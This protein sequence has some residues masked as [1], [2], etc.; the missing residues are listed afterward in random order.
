M[1]RAATLRKQLTDSGLLTTEELSTLPDL[2]T[3]ERVMLGPKDVGQENLRRTWHAIDHNTSS[4]Q[5]VEM[6]GVGAQAVHRALNQSSCGRDDD[7]ARDA[8]L[9]RLTAIELG[10]YA[11]QI[12]SKRGT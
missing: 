7:T 6:A 4:S 9:R 10:L 2:A 5:V 3:L 11:A 8:A 12:E 1:G